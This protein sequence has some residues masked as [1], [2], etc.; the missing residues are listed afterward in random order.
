ML[1][2]F[3]A[4]ISV[5]LQSLQLNWWQG[6][7]FFILIL[8]AILLAFSAPIRTYIGK[9]LN[10]LF[11]KHRSCNDCVSIV[12]S[13]AKQTDLKLKNILQKIEYVNKT[14]L[15]KQMNF[16]EVKL[17]EL[18]NKF[19]DF[20]N[21]RLA[22]SSI[23]SQDTIGETVQYRMFWGLLKEVVQIRVKDEI[24]RCCK[25]N[26]FNELSGQLFS[27]YVKDKNK[28][29]VNMIR[30]HII[31]FYPSHNMNITMHE[32]LLH[33]ETIEPKIE[34][35]M[36]DIFNEVKKIHNNDIEEIKQLNESYK[37]Q[38]DQFDQEVNALIEQV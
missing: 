11:R 13:K 8:F 24:R 30:Q 4:D 34:D 3:W 32:L 5:W 10:K 38:L 15:K 12:S 20:Y 26:G 23:K 9:S 31:N 35:L 7:I 6:L 27:N 22:T 18:E 36:F 17:D 28:Q 19:I 37:E 25:E 1:T 29:V 33:I 21:D 16:S 2:S 14:T